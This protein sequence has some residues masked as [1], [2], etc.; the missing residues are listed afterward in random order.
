VLIVAQ[1]L[2]LVYLVTFGWALRDLM[3]PPGDPEIA[4]RTRTVFANAAWLV[5]NLIGLLAYVYRKQAFGRA[6]ILVVL[7]F[8]I[9]NSLFAAAGFILQSD[10]YT[11]VQW[12]VLTVIPT[13]ALVLVLLQRWPSTTSPPASRAPSS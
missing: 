3:L 1:C 11:A 8:D 6:V 4:V 2:L 9:L 12:F 7:A 10:S 13:A 5:V